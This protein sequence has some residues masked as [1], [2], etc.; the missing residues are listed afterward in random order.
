MHKYLQERKMSD[1]INMNL[2]LWLFLRGHI[3][4]TIECCYGQWVI[5]KV[6]LMPEGQQLI[7]LNVHHVPRLTF[8]ECI[9]FTSDFSLKSALY[10]M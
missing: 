5:N 8:Y 2:M 7:F 6:G 1:F 9:V 4:L 10:F 3:M